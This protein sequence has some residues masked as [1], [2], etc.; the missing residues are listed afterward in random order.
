MVYNIGFQASFC[1][2]ARS[3]EPGTSPYHVDM[4]TLTES[5]TSV[6]TVVVNE[7]NGVQVTKRSI[8]N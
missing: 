4:S 2:R 6:E 1:R 8:S 7:K 3:V 5:S